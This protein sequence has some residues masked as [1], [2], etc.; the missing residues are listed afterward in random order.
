ME[1]EINFWAVLLATVSS[2]V[3]GTIWYAKGVF[4]K[5]WAKLVKIDLNDKKMKEGAPKAIA[6]TILVSFITAY[7]L[8]HLSFL[9]HEFFKNSFLQDS[10]TTAF[11]VWLGFTAARIITHDV[12]ERRPAKLTFITITHEFVTIMVMGLIIGLMGAGQN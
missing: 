7:V 5:T 2:M 11:W 6:L 8:A 10:L 3:V 12:F 9:S 4:G 1:V